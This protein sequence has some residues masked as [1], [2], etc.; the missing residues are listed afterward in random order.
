VPAVPGGPIQES[1]RSAIRAL[2]LARLGLAA[3]HGSLSGA[4]VMQWTRGLNFKYER[5]AFQS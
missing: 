5:I 4:I 1:R 3:I 2:A